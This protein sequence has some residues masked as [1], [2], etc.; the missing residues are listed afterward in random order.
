MSSE[1]SQ[2]WKKAA[3]NEFESLIKNEMWDLVDLPP[4][5]T[6]IGCKWVMKTKR[7]ADGSINR[8]KARL[9][10]QGYS[11]KYG[12]DYDEVFSPVVKYSSIHGLLAIANQYNMEIH[13][14]GCKICLFKW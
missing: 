6:T 7:N 11:Q 10:T 3:D 4:G 14:M 13:Q 8:Y 1:E 9:V 5:K 12:I 2:Q